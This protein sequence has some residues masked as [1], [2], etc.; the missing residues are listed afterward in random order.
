M[1]PEAARSASWRR[2]ARQRWASAA[3]VWPARPNGS[4][5]AALSTTRRSAMS[6][7]S[8]GTRAAWRKEP[9]T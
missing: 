6:A 5:C 9:S 3:R 4:A 7:R 8:S 1:T 2:P